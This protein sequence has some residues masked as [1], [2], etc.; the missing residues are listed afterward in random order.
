MRRPQRQNAHIKFHKNRFSRSRSETHEQT[1][2][3]VNTR[4][5]TTIRKSSLLHDK[6]RA[7]ITPPP[8]SPRNISRTPSRLSQSHL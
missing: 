3:S 5:D 8:P 4:T 6:Q 2:P 1:R 7:A